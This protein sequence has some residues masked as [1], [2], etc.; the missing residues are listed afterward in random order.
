MNDFVLKKIDL[1][2]EDS[3]KKKSGGINLELLINYINSKINLNYSN[4]DS[5]QSLESIIIVN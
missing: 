5:T 2:I 3:M 1:A 4:E